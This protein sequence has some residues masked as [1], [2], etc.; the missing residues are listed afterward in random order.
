MGAKL[1]ESTPDS[2]ADAMCKLGRGLWEVRPRQGLLV[3]V[4]SKA[5]RLMPDKFHGLQDVEKRYRQ[6]Y[7]DMIANPEVMQ[8]FRARSLIVST[9]RRVLEAQNF[10]EVETPV[11]CL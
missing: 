10:L 1:H 4:L 3:Q 11:R 9:L 8:T 2:D 7:L 5:L 6:R